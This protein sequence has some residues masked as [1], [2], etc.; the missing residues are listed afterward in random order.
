MA[1]APQEDELLS[2]WLHRLGLANGIAPRHFASVFEMGGGMW[3]AR[4]DLFLPDGMSRLLY[5]HSGIAWEALAQMASAQNA[6]SP[7]LLPLRQTSSR[8]R[9]T[10][11]QFCP[12]CLASD[13]SPY[14]RRRWRLATSISCPTHGSGLRDRCP[15]CR[16]GMAVFDQ[17][18]LVPQHCCAM[19]GFDLK[20]APRVSVKAATR[21]LERCIHDILRLEVAKGFLAKSS[22]IARLLSLP[23]AVDSNSAR[24]LINLSSVA[25]IRCFDQVAE[26]CHD[27]LTAGTE[28]SEI[29]FWRQR[30]LAVGSLAAALQPLCQWMRERVVIE[31]EAPQRRID[32]RGIDL[33][34]LIDAYRRARERQLGG[35]DTRA[36]R[37]VGGRPRRS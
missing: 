27:H 6:L 34:A 32:T 37:P 31:D 20:Y 25:R 33:S 4:L 14:F 13:T 23:T 1:V 18:D 30:I 36:Y 26:E 2:S 12:Q 35:H 10:W 29:I 21:R 28:A 24:T 17:P 11:L 16:H 22:L 8:R 15:S 5:D 3:S 19:C 9:A 7:L